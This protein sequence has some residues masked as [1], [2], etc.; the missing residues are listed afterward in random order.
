[1]DIPSAQTPI[2]KQPPPTLHPRPHLSYNQSTMIYK[3][4]GIE[5]PK[6]WGDKS[7]P[8]NIGEVIEFEVNEARSNQVATD[9][10]LFDLY[11][12]P[13]SRKE[14]FG[15]KYLDKTKFP[16][17]IKSIFS[18]ENLSLQVH[19]ETKNEVWY[20][21]KDNSK[22]ILGLKDDLERDDVDEVVD[23]INLVEADEGDF[24]IVDA[25]T[26][27]SIMADTA[28]CEVQDNADET[29]RLYDWGRDREL[30]IDE[31]FSVMDKTKIDLDKK[32]QKSFQSYESPN[33]AI[34]KI[35]IN[36]PRQFPRQD[37]C[38]V[39]IITKGE[40]VLKTA[41]DE[42][43]IHKKDCFLVPAHH[44]YTLDGDLEFLKVV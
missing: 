17:L 14:I 6:V 22:V 3:T 20:F 26:V 16:F 25:G 21:L 39:L 8:N 11:K 36:S 15:E 35:T 34:E 31:A 42:L 44:D 13:Q 10:T 9:T 38:N 19:P 4:T 24:A 2:T 1:M 32:F 43:K 7:T 29:L 33:F 27:H 41:E 37:F 18:S 30:A 12:N 5:L 23:K 40:G 28:V